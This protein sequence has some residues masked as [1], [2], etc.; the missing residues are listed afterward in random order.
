MGT[1]FVFLTPLTYTEFGQLLDAYYEKRNAREIYNLMNT[2]KKKSE[3][4][5]KKL[6]SHDFSLDTEWHN[7]GTRWIK[8]EAANGC[9][10]ALSHV[11]GEVTE[12]ELPD[13]LK[14]HIAKQKPL[15]ITK[16]W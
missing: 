16:W 7:E 1:V 10:Q 6:S 9:Q 4:Y 13:Y 15:L 14:E 12:F 11:R 5:E 8:F 3:T 2:F